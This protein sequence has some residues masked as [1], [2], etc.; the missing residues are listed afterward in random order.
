[1]RS[2]QN[3]HVCSPTISFTARGQGPIRI[4]SEKRLVYQTASVIPEQQAI[5][6]A[7]FTMVRPEEVEEKRESI[8]GFFG[9]PYNP[10]ITADFLDQF[11]NLKVVATHSQGYDH[12]DLQACKAREIRVCTV[13]SSLSAT[14]AD[15]AFAL[16]LAASRRVVEGNTRARSMSNIWSNDFFGM[17]VSGSVLGIVGMGKIGFEVAKRGRG[18]SMPILY[19]NRNRR[20]KEI[21]DEVHATYVATLH[22][23]LAQ[24]DFIVVAAPG[25]K[26]NHHMFDSQEF[27]NMK[28]TSV[29]VNIGRGSLVNHDA[30]VEALTKGK[31]AAAGLDV[32]DPEPLPPSH[33]LF[34]LNNVTITPHIGDSEA[35]TCIICVVTIIPTQEV[36]Q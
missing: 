35:L 1:M 2:Q 31:I 11:P 29:F 10:R 33:P 6:D 14:I 24:S 36:R 4:M 5:L 12:I 20:S 19:H 16:L 34:S 26:E 25:T 7:A 15:M 21:E 8:V 27:S 18:F 32:T 9:D 28:S 30:L 22:D 13:G 3:T 17:E 23:L